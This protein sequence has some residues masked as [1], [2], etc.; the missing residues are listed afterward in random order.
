MVAA[1][2]AARSIAGMSRLLVV[3]D[4][5][6]VMG[7]LRALLTR[8]GH[9]V[10][11]ARDGAQALRELY[12]SR[13][14]LVLLDVG[15][16]VMDGWTVLGRVRELSDLPVI[17][18]TGAQTELDAVRG[19]RAGADDFV[20]KP[21]GRQELLARVD[22]VLRRTGG[23]GSELAPDHYDDGVI[24]VDFGQ[25]VA[26]VGGRELV[27][28]PLE[29]RLLAAFARHAG[30]V[31]SA[32][33]LLALAWEGP[34]PGREQVKANVAA[35]RRKLREQGAA[36]VTIETVRGFGYRYRPGAPDRS[37]T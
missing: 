20:T 16:P 10:V 32:E 35:L 28:T 24:A 23:R 22:A 31:L 34:P 8:A 12:R 13:P 11:E 2:E 4:D 26:A 33:Q 1:T 19:L 21:F 14:E 3:D 6:T 37:R 30:Q 5:E 36:A 25:R 18:L 17:M 27:L 15:L 9:E 7:M 29:Y